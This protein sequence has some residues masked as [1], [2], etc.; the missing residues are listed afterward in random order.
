M[1]FLL[2][3][4]YLTKKGF[5]IIIFKKLEILC[6]IIYK[7]VRNKKVRNKKVRNKKSTQ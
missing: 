7:K 5:K 2:I 1:F 3:K 4:H 6:Q